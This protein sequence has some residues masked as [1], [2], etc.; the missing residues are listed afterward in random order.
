V[1]GYSSVWKCMFR[2]HV[3]NVSEL[4]LR[5]G[6]MFELVENSDA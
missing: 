6:E 3:L 1:S 5:P 4:N 2:G